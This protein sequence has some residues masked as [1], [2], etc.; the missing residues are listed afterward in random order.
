MLLDLRP[1]PGADGPRRARATP[2]RC[3]ETWPLLRAG[4]VRAVSESGVLGDPTGANAAEGATLLDDL[5]AAADP[6][7]GRLAARR[8]RSA[9]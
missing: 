3:P 9:R 7:R 6:R 8:A 4:G 1:D 5:A 2:A